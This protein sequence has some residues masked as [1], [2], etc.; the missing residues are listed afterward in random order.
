MRNSHPKGSVSRIVSFCG[1]LQKTD[2]AEAHLA[3]TPEAI[4]SGEP[5]ATWPWAAKDRADAFADLVLAE[6]QSD[7][8]AR[9]TTTQYLLQAVEHGRHVQTYRIR[10]LPMEEDPWGGT[11]GS[12]AEIVAQT[13]KHNEV[14]LRSLIQSNEAVMSQQGKVIELM[15]RR[16]EVIEETHREALTM[17]SDAAKMQAVAESDTGDADA[18]RE[19]WD[20]VLRLAEMAVAKAM[21]SGEANKVVKL[22]TAA[23]KLGEGGDGK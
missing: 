22:A 1:R 21:E 20:R 5:I 2:D 7:A 18:R 10:C 13:Q 11:G 14:L 8:D 23:K 15:A 17:Y 16:L 19:R 6:A 9:G 12:I 4:Q 3:L